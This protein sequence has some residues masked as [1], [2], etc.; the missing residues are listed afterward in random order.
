[1]R[2]SKTRFRAAAYSSDE[3]WSRFPASYMGR[4]EDKVLR[5]KPFVYGGRLNRRVFIGP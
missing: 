2:R 3:G 4:E 5:V 1:M